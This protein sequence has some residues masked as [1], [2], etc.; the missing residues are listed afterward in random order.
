MKYDFILFIFCY[1]GYIWSIFSFC[2]EYLSIS[3]INKII[4]GILLFTTEMLFSAFNEFIRMPYI[5]NVILIN[6]LFISLFFLFFRGDKAEKLFTA[7]TLITVKTLVWNFSCSFLSFVILIL[8]NTLTNGKITFINMQTDNVIASLACLIL[9]AAIISLKKKF[10]AVFNNK[11]KNWFLIMSLSMMFIVIIVEVVN[12]GASNGIMVVSNAN[13]AA[14]WNIYYNQLFSHTAICLLTIL[15]TFIAAGLVFGTNK[16]YTEQIQKEQYHS[17]I[18]FYKMLNEQY[19][20]MERLRHDMKNHMLSLYSLCQNRELDK[21]ENYIANMMESGN[22][23]T[24]NDYA[25]GNTVI[26]ALL[27]NKGKLALKNEIKWECNVQIPKNCQIYEFDLC[28]LFGNI[29]DNAI[30]S[31]IKTQN[32]EQKFIYVQSMRVKNCL[33]LVVKNGTTLS[34]IN[35]VKNGIGLLNV[36]D[37]AY[38]YNGVINKKLENHIFEI[39][40][41][42]PLNNNAHDIK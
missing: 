19:S 35:E 1:M 20:Q 23:I 21:L 5:F 17:R 13:G 8:L 12:W 41:L 3:K 16:I 18:E 10:A 38:K 28:V 42:F 15:S 40:L 30:N 22:I 14:Y 29:L 24:A 26:D 4:F 7:V 11:I 6:T 2:Q 9:I 33:L 25:S 39:S 32:K 36:Y 37:T 31:C 27:Y 34:S